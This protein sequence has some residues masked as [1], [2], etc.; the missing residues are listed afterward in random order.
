LVT[1]NKGTEIDNSA[2][3]KLSQDGSLQP[4]TQQPTKVPEPSAKQAS[5]APEPNANPSDEASEPNAPP[6][7]APE[8]A[9]GALGPDADHPDEEPATEAQQPGEMDE[10]HAAEDIYPNDDE[11][12]WEGGAGHDG[13][14]VEL[15]EKEE[16]EEVTKKTKRGKNKN[17]RKGDKAK[18]SRKPTEQEILQ[19]LLEKNEV[20]LQLSHKNVQL[21]ARVKALSDIRVQLMAEFDNYRKRT[22]KEWDLLKDQTKVEVLIEFLSVVDDFDRAMTAMGERDDEFVQG[23]RLIYNGLL[24]TLERLG[25]RKMIA[26]GESFDPKAH[27]AVASIDSENVESNHIVEVIQEGYLMN[28]NVIRPANVVIAK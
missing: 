18:S 3:E 20:I 11:V 10:D 16:V 6:A 12:V 25:V 2:E 27:M 23:V 13:G 14:D 1:K 7:N 5:E 26:L 22:R 21:D 4:D 17:R 24:S 28:G 19:R 9:N 8:Q 15:V